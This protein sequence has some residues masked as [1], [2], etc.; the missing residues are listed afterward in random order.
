MN[1]VRRY[2]TLLVDIPCFEAPD[3]SRIQNRIWKPRIYR[4]E[5]MGAIGLLSICKD[6]DMN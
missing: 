5:V 4:P 3:V 1:S 2:S 6:V